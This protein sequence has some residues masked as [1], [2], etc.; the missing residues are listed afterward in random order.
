MSRIV[1]VSFRN[2][3]EG[4]WKQIEEVKGS[5][6]TGTKIRDVLYDWANINTE[7]NENGGDGE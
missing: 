3:D 1:T 5:P 2:E 4:I 7:K 6:V